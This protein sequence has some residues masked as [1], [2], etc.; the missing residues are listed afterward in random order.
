MGFRSRYVKELLTLL[1]DC[2]ENADVCITTIEL[3]YAN[4]TWDVESST[5]EIFSVRS[6]SYI[7]NAGDVVNGEYVSLA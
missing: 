5:I 2:D 7:D 3:D 1:N 4:S 6:G